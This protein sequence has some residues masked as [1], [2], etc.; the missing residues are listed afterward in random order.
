MFSIHQLSIAGIT[1]TILALGTA[2][3]GKAFSIN[4]PANG[5]QYFLTTTDTWTGAQALAVAAGGN[6][7]TINDAEEQAWLISTFGSNLPFW[8]GLN[9]IEVEGQFKWVSGQRITYTNWLPSEPD[10]FLHIPEGEDFVQMFGSAGTWADTTTYLLNLP[11]NFSQGIVEIETPP[12][13][14]PRHHPRQP[15]E[16]ASTLLQVPVESWWIPKSQPH[17]YL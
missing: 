9:D 5:H 3:V 15:G 13:S 4:N 10:N 16:T 2:N 14:V 1:A 8:I 17:R 12:K 11:P 6:L 7:V